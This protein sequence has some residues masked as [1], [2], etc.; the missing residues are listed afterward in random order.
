MPNRLPQSVHSGSSRSRTCVWGA[1]RGGGRSRYLSEL[2]VHSERLSKSVVRL[3]RLSGL[4]YVRGTC[5][6]PR[7]WGAY[8][9][10]SCIRGMRGSRAAAPR[11]ALVC[12]LGRC[13]K[14]GGASSSCGFEPGWAQC[15]VRF[16]RFFRIAQAPGERR[17]IACFST[18]ENVC[19]EGWTRPDAWRLTTPSADGRVL[20]RVL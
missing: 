6:S 5:R 20:V 8:R 13:E 3:G 7:V 9:G 15:L 4:P 11:G 2:V 12:C 18:C 1:C 17:P 10:S 19:Q 14:G 16:G